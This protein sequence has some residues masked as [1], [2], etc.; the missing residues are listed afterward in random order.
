MNNSAATVAAL[1]QFAR[2]A[3]IEVPGM[4][5]FRECLLDQ[6]AVSKHDG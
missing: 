1:D 2:T 4:S 3:E 5:G 6:Y